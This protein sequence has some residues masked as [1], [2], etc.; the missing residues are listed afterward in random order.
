[1]KIYTIINICIIIVIFILIIV[2]IDTLYM[3][4]QINKA[5]N[6]IGG[7]HEYSG[8]DSYCIYPDNYAIEVIFDCKG[9]FF[10]KQCKALQI[11]KYME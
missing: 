8:R 2:V 9:L 7:K 5:C 4:N 6:D 1:M 10:N 3:E 11:I